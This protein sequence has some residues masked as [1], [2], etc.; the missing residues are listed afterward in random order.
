MSAHRT[1]ARPAAAKQRPLRRQVRRMLL[2][3]AAI[4]REA[5]DRVGLSVED[6]DTGIALMALGLELL[7]ARHTEPQ[8]RSLFERLLAAPIANDIRAD[9]RGT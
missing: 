3:R 4:L 7:E 2:A 6:D 8:L 1:T 5:L 9:T